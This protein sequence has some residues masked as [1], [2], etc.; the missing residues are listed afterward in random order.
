MAKKIYIGNLSFSTV[1]DTLS[2]YFASFGEVISSVIIKDKV[3]QNSKGF[4]FVEMSDDISAQ[5]AVDS[6]NGRE[7]DGRK[8]RVS[9]AEEKKPRSRPQV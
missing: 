9:Y 7:I 5:K 6:L 3:T 8:V 4:G 1:E 2:E